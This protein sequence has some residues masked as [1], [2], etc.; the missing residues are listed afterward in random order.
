ML[1]KIKAIANDRLVNRIALADLIEDMEKEH[2]FD[3]SQV[4]QTTPLLSDSTIEYPKLEEKY[5]IENE[6]DFM[7]IL[8]YEFE[9]I[10]GEY[11]K[12]ANNSKVTA[13]NRGE[14]RP[15]VQ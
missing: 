3:D 9:H 13:A 8:K 2:L 10:S 1:Q 4:N 15:E 6:K 11:L 5:S 12:L 7:S 14:S